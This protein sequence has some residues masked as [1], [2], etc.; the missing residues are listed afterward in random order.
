MKK[1]LSLLLVLVLL[2]G[3]VC[4][5]AAADDAVA[6]LQAT[7]PIGDVN[8]D[9]T[10]NAKDVTIL[11]RYLAGGYG[12]T[13]DPR[14]A[15]ASG[16][17]TLSAKDITYLRRYLAGGYNL[18]LGVYFDTPELNY[19]GAVTGGQLYTD[20]GAPSFG[21][22]TLTVTVDGVEQN[23]APYAAKIAAD[24]TEALTP[25]NAYTEAVKD[26]SAK[27]I[28]LTVSL[29]FGDGGVQ[30]RS[31]TLA[32]TGGGKYRLLGRA[33][34]L[35]DSVNV[36]W[37]ADGVEFI[38]DCGGSIY[39][40]AQ[41][42][43]E[44]R[45]AS[46]NPA[47]KLHFRVTV[48][49]AIGDWVEFAQD[50]GLCTKLAFSDLPAGLHTIRI[51]KDNTVDYGIYKL[52]S[53]TFNGDPDSVR[54][55]APRPK[56]LEIIGASTACGAGILPTPDDGYSVGTNNTATIV[57]SF[58]GLVADD[59]NMDYSAIVKG[60]LGI[61]AQAG[62]FDKFNLPE[63]YPYRNRYRDA[64]SIKLGEIDGTPEEYDFARPADVVILM[65]NE[66]DA[67][68]ESEVWVP[69]TKAFIE[70]IREKNGADV[71]ILILYYSGSAH[72]TDILGILADDPT[73]LSLAIRSNSS[74]SGGHASGAAHRDWADKLIPLIRPLIED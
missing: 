17:G 55:S 13:I 71:P 15:D 4:V 65:I 21:E 44:Y 59:L 19:R 1:L 40:T 72:K 38:A 3:C 28:A 57:Y 47:N 37:Q 69:A 20:L 45:N 9:G 70:T 60:S 63:L 22:Y 30:Y 58:G 50:E 52:I 16:D 25:E 18:E 67:S 29:L 7:K 5:S 12:V 61:T 39:L 41:A 31:T 34:Q 62:R 2:L 74:G 49:G 66:N 42:V 73:L 14:A 51:L 68:T 32:F 6:E 35:E 64:R 43:R 54:P 33:K 46:G 53:A 36:D 48:D 26:E 23:A 8:G 11:R 56:Y 24:N 10:I 27:T